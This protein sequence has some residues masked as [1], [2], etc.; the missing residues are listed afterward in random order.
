MT[1]ECIALFIGLLICDKLQKTQITVRADSKSL[2][3]FV[4]NESKVPWNVRP[5]FRKNIKIQRYST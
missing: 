4:K 3:E 1:A 2:I 5:L